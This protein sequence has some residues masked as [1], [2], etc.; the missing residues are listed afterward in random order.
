MIALKH[1][2]SPVVLG[3]LLA[4]A[5]AQSLELEVVGGSLPGDI[6]M[7]VSPGLYPFEL[8]MIVPSTTSGPTPIG[9][10]DPGDPRSLSVGLDLLGFAWPVA[11]D[12][13]LV[14]TQ[15]V[16][17]TASP[18]LVGQALYFQAVTFRWQPTILDRL[19]NADVLR[20]GNAGQFEDRSVFMFEQ[21]A[22]ATALE[23]PDRKTLVVGGARGQL[24]AQVATDTTEVYDPITDSFNYGPT[25]TTPRSMH[26]QTEL[27]NGTFLFVGGVDGANNPQSSCEIYDPVADTFTLVAPMVSPRMGHTATL[28]ADGRVFVAGGLDALTVT[29]TQ[30]SAIR[31]A[32]DTTE[33]Y[34]PVTDS[35]TSG[36]A[37]SD[38]RAA[39]LAMQR[40]DGKILLA[41]G[42]SWSPNIIFGWVPTVR[43]SCDL[44]DPSNN[45]MSSGP[46][47]ATS[48]ALTEAVELAPGRW[49]VAGGMNGLSI[50]PFN[51]GNPTGTA[52]IYDSTL[53]TW[54]SVGSLASARANLKGWSIGNGQFLIA[55][56]GAG[57][58]LSPTPLSDTEIFDTATNTFSPGPTMN[59]GRAG[60][61]MFFTPQGQVHLFGG[62]ATSS[63]IT[64][65]T[66]WYFF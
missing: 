46:S 52:E 21:R 4:T 16:S 18:A 30:L 32:V 45:T 40:P 14:A 64:T 65:T 37:M 66:E 58:I 43:S 57:S 8:M 1:V 42:I 62:A 47:M 60:A 50:I 33:I 38:P 10:F 15:Q 41:G 39:H 7:Q 53:N 28:L 5:S 22:F 17:L 31:D 36:P 23:R 54:T 55:G 59:S 63:S 3:S 27:Q 26:T 34:D 9:L 11:A 29:P 25:M 13:N 48:R 24:L 19:S 35:W 49:L 44:Y 2:L 51:P 6:D 61:G 56:G 20:F 12:L